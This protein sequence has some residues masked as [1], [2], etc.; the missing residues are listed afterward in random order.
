MPV[1]T[2]KADSATVLVIGQEGHGKTTLTAA[3]VKVLSTKKKAKATSESSLPSDPRFNATEVI[4]DKRTLTFID[5]TSQENYKSYAE[6]ARHPVDIVLLVVDIEAGV[7]DETK[8]QL[9]LAKPFIKPEGN[10][11][12]FL[13]KLDKAE[14]SDQVDLIELSIRGFFPSVGVD[15]EKGVMF[16]GSASLL[17]DSNDRKNQKPVIKM[18]ECL[19]KIPVS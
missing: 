3:V 8:S 9:E 1:A 5:F 2:S 17:L 18:M 12:V 14:D 7:G 15:S 16:R 13:N 4:S 11:V 19:N 6:E 10:I